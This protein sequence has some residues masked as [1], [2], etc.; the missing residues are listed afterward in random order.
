[1]A[2][3]DARRG[4]AAYLVDRANWARLA[5]ALVLLAG[6]SYWVFA[7]DSPWTRALEAA[8]G[9]LPEMLPGLQAVEPARSVERLGP[10]RADWLRWQGYDF[11]FASLN[12]AVFW[13]A[14]GLGVKALRGRLAWTLWLPAFYMLTEIVEGIFLA[15]FASGVLPPQGVPALTQQF[16]TTLKF[17]FA[18]V[19][20][21]GSVGM[22]L[23]AIVIAMRR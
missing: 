4:L 2:E 3:D 11:F 18:A 5:I 8:G 13:S 22:I 16:A 17:G 10:A 20:N 21:L 12:A 7:L 14:I 9:T 15:A 19:C 6:F 23:T 1:M